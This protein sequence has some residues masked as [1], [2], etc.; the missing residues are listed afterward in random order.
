MSVREVREIVR[1]RTV[2][3]LLGSEFRADNPRSIGGLIG[4]LFATIR[5]GDDPRLVMGEITGHMTA[6]DFVDN[7]V[8]ELN[9]Q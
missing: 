6:L 5:R 7:A 8:A 1:A 9:E 4:Q 3:S 2:E